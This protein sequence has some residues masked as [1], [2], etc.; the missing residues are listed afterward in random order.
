MRWLRTR[1][2]WCGTCHHVRFNRLSKDSTTTSNEADPFAALDIPPV[3][4]EL[5]GSALGIII[6][7]IQF[8]IQFY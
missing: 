3:P 8:A 7:K 2:G 6:L 5:P 1:K 4:I